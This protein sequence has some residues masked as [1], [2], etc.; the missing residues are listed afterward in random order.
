MPTIQQC[1]V[2]VNASPGLN[3]DECHATTQVVSRALSGLAIGQCA[4]GTL[5]SFK[6]ELARVANTTESRVYRIDVEQFGHSFAVAQ[7]GAKVVVMQSWVGCY[8]LHDWM[9]G[10]VEDLKKNTF[11]PIKGE[12]EHSV[13]SW[14]LDVISQ[15]LR[16]GNIDNVYKY[17]LALFNPLPPR[18]TTMRMALGYARGNALSLKWASRAIP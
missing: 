3:T 17:G 5:D 6:A 4:D 16:A 11:L 8:S 7:S 2:R 9:R 12:T 13:L 1:I 18:T 15:D 14:Y 10:E